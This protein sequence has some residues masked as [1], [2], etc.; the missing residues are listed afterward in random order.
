MSAELDANTN[1]GQVAHVRHKPPKPLGVPRVLVL[2]CAARSAATSIS[3]NSSG[4]GCCGI[5]RR[6]DCGHVKVDQ[7]IAGRRGPGGDRRPPH[8]AEVIRELKQAGFTLVGLEAN[9]GLEE[10]HECLPRKTAHPPPPHG[11]RQRSG[12]A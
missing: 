9:D 6:I 2:V 3:P 7:T 10:H 12:S 8:A 11:A 1:S 5:T 4:R